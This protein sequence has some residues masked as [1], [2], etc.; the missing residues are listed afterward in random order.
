MTRQAPG[1]LLRPDMLV[2]VAREADAVVGFAEATSR[3]DC[4]NGCETSPVAFVEGLL[5]CRNGAPTALRERWSQL[6]RV[7]RESAV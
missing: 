5:C 4:V 3:R 1:I 2:L 7:G 6:S